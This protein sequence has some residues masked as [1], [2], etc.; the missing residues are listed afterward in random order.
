MISISVVASEAAIVAVCSYD[1][2]ATPLLSDAVVNGGFSVVAPF[3]F[4]WSQRR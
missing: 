2:W 4:S 1:G 3:S